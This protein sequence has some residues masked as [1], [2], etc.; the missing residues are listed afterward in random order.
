[1][2]ILDRLPNRRV[3]VM[4]S[5]GH[6][7]QALPPWRPEMSTCDRMYIDMWNLQQRHD[8]ERREW[9]ERAERE[10]ARSPEELG[11]VPS[12]NLLQAEADARV[13]GNGNAGMLAIRI[14]QYELEYWW[15]KRQRQRDSKT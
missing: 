1:M 2:K 10:R 5:K 9:M 8:Q 11:F 12:A 15:A 14:R 3:R 13:S 6:S 7:K 4:C